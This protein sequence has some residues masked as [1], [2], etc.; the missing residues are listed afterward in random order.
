MLREFAAQPKMVSIAGSAVGQVFLFA[1]TAIVSRVYLPEQIGEYGIYFALF[2]VLQIAAMLRL[3]QAIVYARDEDEAG[4]LA[5]ACLLVL[6]P[7]LLALAIPAYVYLA[8]N[9]QTSAYSVGLLCALVVAVA[10][11]AVTRMSVQTIARSD[12]FM[13]LALINLMRPSLIA[14]FQILAALAGAAHARLTVAFAL[15]QFTLMIGAFALF[16][17]TAGAPL[18]PAP[19]PLL[20]DAARRHKGFVLYSLPQN[21]LFVLSEALVPLSISFIYSDASAVALFW[22]ASRA[23]FA[24]A[25]VVAESIRPQTYRAI[26][27]QTEGLARYVFL[28]SAALFATVALPLLLLFWIGPSLFELAFGAGWRGANDYALVLGGL[29]AVNMAALPFIG[30]LPVLGLQRHY[31]VVELAG[32]AVRAALLFLVVWGDAWTG[33]AVSTLGYVLV[34]LGFLAY[35]ASILVR[36][37]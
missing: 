3:E 19:L 8:R 33:L 17:R 29:V 18:R 15:A 10:C 20:L 9:P 11:S 14:A 4:L 23:V 16:R 34:Q 6:L 32:L 36:R 7:V 26:A 30:A 25:T 37:K 13:T 28:T 35:V 12:S 5:Q 1:A 21:L 27:R 2:N 22:L 24:P 31:V